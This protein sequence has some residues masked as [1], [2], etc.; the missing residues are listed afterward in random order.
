MDQPIFARALVVQCTLDG[1]NADTLHTREVWQLRLDGVY[2]TSGWAYNKDGELL[3]SASYPYFASSSARLDILIGAAAVEDVAAGV[4]P[5]LCPYFRN[6]C[7]KRP[8]VG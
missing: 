3:A 6:H 5:V 1:V 4:E 8:S 7:F 2:I